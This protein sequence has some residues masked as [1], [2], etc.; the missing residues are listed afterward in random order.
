MT[1]IAMTIR[2]V[3]AIVV[4]AMATTAAAEPKPEENNGR[5]RYGDDEGA[6]AT[7]P[8]S[9]TE[10]WIVLATPTPAKHGTEF[11]VVGKDQGM[12]GK[13]RLD[14][15]G[16]VMLRRVKV[17]FDDGSQKTFALDRMLDAKRPF[18][19][20]DLGTPKPIDRV[21]VTTDAQTTG[22]YAIYG[23]SSAGAV[24]GR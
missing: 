4:L 1:S 19:E 7:K 9:Q 3:F 16:T 8:A 5:I 17:Y 14:A 6:H 23:S 20:I 13:L 12:F 24:A 18:T 2:R 21:V 11:V 15:K 10:G 22:E